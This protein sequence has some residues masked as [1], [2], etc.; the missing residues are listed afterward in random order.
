MA[1]DASELESD[2]LR[3]GMWQRKKS[4][5]IVIWKDTEGT[6]WCWQALV[7]DSDVR[8]ALNGSRRDSNILMFPSLHPSL[9][10]QDQYIFILKY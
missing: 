5:S 10:N 3:P 9:I 6:R 1:V 7:V 8:V 4:N 2:S